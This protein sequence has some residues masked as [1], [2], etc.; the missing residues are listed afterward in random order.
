MLNKY[1]R[2]TQRPNLCLNNKRKPNI[3]DSDK[4]Q[5]L[6]NGLLLKL[7]QANTEVAG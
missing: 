5:H 2:E 6:N 4:L 7:G 1:K 3:A